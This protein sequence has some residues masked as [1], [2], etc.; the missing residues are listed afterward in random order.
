MRAVTSAVAAAVADILMRITL[1]VSNVALLVRWQSLKEEEYSMREQ[2]RNRHAISLTHKVRLANMAET[3]PTAS[4]AKA[5]VRKA[6]E[7]CDV[8]GYMA[9]KYGIKGEIGIGQENFEK[10]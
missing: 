7:C 4:A 9:R 3:K 2:R 6:Y 1:A 8:T 5:F 10:T